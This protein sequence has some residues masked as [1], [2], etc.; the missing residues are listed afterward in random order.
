[1][2][3]IWHVFLACP[4]AY[5]CWSVVGIHFNP[6]QFESVSAWFF[7]QIQTQDQSMVAKMSMV[8]WGLWT[9]CDNILWRHA[10]LSPRVV[11]DYLCFIHD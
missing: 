3:H 7:H 9:Q 1:M 11:V 6:N 4:S 5:E 8:L 2:E 10:N